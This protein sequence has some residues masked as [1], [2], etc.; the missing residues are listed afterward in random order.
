MLG[1]RGLE[2]GVG[3]IELLVVMSLLLIALAM[4]GTAFGVVLR[5]SEASRDVGASTD[6]LRQAVQALDRQ[7]RFGYWVRL[8]TV[9]TSTCASPP[10]SALPAVRILTTESPSGSL[11]CWSWAVD[12]NA[13]ALRAYKF[14]TNLAVGDAL[15][16]PIEQ[17]HMVAGPEGETLDNVEVAGSLS[18]LGAEISVLNPSTLVRVSY[19][20]GVRADF[21]LT[22]GERVLSS[23]V[24][25]ATRNQ[26]AGGSMVDMC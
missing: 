15:L 20:A 24:T 7:V 13:H 10:C 23:S 14:P 26:W 5:T 11:R 8:T 9:S 16:P 21:T 2:S 18:G 19:Y 12:P 6:Q 25:V 3:L 4:F 17:W 22:N 1:K